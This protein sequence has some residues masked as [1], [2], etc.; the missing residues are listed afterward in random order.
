MHNPRAATTAGHERLGRRQG[1]TMP[2]ND[3]NSFSGNRRAAIKRLRRLTAL[4]C[5]HLPT[6]MI[7]CASYHLAAYMDVATRERV[8]TTSMSEELESER[9]ASR[10]TVRPELTG[11]DR[12]LLRQ[13]GIKG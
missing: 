5:E 4:A 11:A 12:K 8:L 1:K 6:E 10:R 13:L 2:S 3:P 7:N 9:S